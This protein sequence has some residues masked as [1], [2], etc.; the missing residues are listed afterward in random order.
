MIDIC[1]KKGNYGKF[2]GKHEGYGGVGEF[3][4]GKGFEEYDRG[5]ENGLY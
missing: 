1:R 3:L 5:G 4:G 2:D